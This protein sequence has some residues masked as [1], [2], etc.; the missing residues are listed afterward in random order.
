MTIE[1]INEYIAFHQR[2]IEDLET[3]KFELEA[4]RKEAD[5]TL[6]MGECG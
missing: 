6:C 2:Q 3:L 4:A 1:Q 5:C